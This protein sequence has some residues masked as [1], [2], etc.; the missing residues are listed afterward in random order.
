M[1]VM[2]LVVKGVAV[3]V[4]VVDGVVYG[5]ALLYI[6]FC[7][8]Y[9]CIFFLCYGSSFYF[10]AV[11]AVVVLRVN[12]GVKYILVKWASE[13]SK[14]HSTIFH[15]CSVGYLPTLL[16]LPTSLAPVKEKKKKKNHAH[17]E[18][19]GSVSKILFEN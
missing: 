3:V 17:D 7:R 10:F 8:C 19:G 16:A 12:T 6:I 15:F 5:V 18:R 14:R 1:V 9:C 4:L 11:P 13:L 2:V